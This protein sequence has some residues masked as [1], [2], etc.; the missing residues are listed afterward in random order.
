M[1]V[2]SV[3]A[4]RSGCSVWGNLSFH[5]MNILPQE[6]KGKVIADCY[7]IGYGLAIIEFTD[8]TKLKV[9][10]DKVIITEKYSTEIYMI[11]EA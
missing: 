9:N 5:F 1:E 11:L 3:L 7:P 10:Y 6:L 4:D 8:G 2:G